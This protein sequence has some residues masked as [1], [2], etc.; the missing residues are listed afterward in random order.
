MGAPPTARPLRFPIRTKCMCGYPRR[1]TRSPLAHHHLQTVKPSQIPQ[2]TRGLR[3]SPL[4]AWSMGRERTELTPVRRG[5][6]PRGNGGSRV[7]VRRDGRRMEP[8][9]ARGAKVRVL[10]RTG[11]DQGL[12]AC[13]ASSLEGRGGT[14][15][16]GGGGPGAS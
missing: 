10:G 3:Y 11:G 8:V 1:T 7:G 4:P 12:K 14:G 15:W 2:L 5:P 6:C 16:A 9:G 13:G